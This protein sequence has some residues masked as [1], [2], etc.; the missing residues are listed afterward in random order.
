VPIEE[1]M[2]ERISALWSIIKNN[3]QS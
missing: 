1:L 3:L 2:T